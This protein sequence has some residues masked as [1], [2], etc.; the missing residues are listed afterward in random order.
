MTHSLTIKK[1]NI[2]Q[3]DCFQIEENR[4]FLWVRLD[5]V[6]PLR[7]LRNSI[8][9]GAMVFSQNHLKDFSKT[10]VLSLPRPLEPQPPGVGL[11]NALFLTAPSVTL[12]ST[13]S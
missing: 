5:Q 1:K 3:E 6:E 8:K 7:T 12:T 9:M 2:S 4:I 11:K 13:Q 10:E